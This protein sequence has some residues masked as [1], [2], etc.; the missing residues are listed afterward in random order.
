MQLDGY[1]AYYGFIACNTSCVA[2]KLD[3]RQL[4]L[5]IMCLTKTLLSHNRIGPMYPHRE[6]Y[7][8]CPPAHIQDEQL[9]DFDGLPYSWKHS[10]PLLL[11]LVTKLSAISVL[12]FLRPRHHLA[13][14]DDQKQQNAVAESADE[15][16]ANP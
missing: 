15:V 8:C 14:G 9:L 4:Q 1:Q 16:D 12:L 13:N 6:A 10:V 7:S 3:E 2:M 5:P 11:V